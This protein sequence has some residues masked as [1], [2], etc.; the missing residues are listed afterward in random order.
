MAEPF[1]V[2]ALI[3]EQE[4]DPFTFTFGG[5]LYTCVAEIDIR[6]VRA[7]TTGDLDGAFEM[8]LGPEQRDR[9]MASPQ[10]LSTR[11][12]VAILQAY[13]KHSG[14]TLPNLPLPSPPYRN[15]AAP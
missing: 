5:E 7:L 4:G 3:A 8:L 12:F 2:D 1:D 14:I 10:V 15:T 6:A 9:L 13:A 11:A